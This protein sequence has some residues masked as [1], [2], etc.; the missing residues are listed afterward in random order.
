MSQVFEQNVANRIRLLNLRLADKKI[1]L[2]S[3]RIAVMTF[4]IFL[5]TELCFKNKKRSCVILERLKG[6]FF[7]FDMKIDWQHFIRFLVR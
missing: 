2:K 4:F 3:F 1:A 7:V 6:Y 5:Q